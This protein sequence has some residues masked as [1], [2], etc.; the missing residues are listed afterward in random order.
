M[1]NLFTFLWPPQLDLIGEH[2][3]DKDHGEVGVQRAVVQQAHHNISQTLL[4]KKKKRAIPQMMKQSIQRK[5]KKYL[6]MKKLYLNT[7]SVH[8][9]AWQPKLS[10][11]TRWTFLKSFQ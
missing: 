3:V 11:T 10:T 7:Q 1:S 8:V 6:R 9:F 4:R 2:S 5:R